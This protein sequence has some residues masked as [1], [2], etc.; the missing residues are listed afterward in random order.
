MPKITIKSLIEHS[1]APHHILVRDEL[2]QLGFSARSWRT[3]RDSG[4]IH[5]VHPGVAVT[6]GR[7]LDPVARIAAAVAAVGEGAMASHKSAA[8]LWGADV[9]GVEPI[10]VLR[11]DRRAVVHLQSVRIHRPFDTLD[12]HVQEVHGVPVSNPLRTLLDLGA[13]DRWAVDRALQTFVIKGLVTPQSVDNALMRHS[14]RGRH[15]MVALRTALHRLVLTERPP[16]S[17]L[18]EQMARLARRFGLPHMQFHARLAGYEV[19]FLVTGTRLYIECEG[20]TYHGLDKE[21]F[22]FDRIRAAQ[23][24]AN[25]YVGLRFTWAQIMRRPEFVARQITES[26][27]TW[28]GAHRSR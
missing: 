23:L 8:F 5:E 20:W 22:E 26:L 19:D 13:V 3:A 1:R 24:L 6:P 12:L 17:V 28:V 10:D 21:Q 4:L 11:P 2:R 9:V 16:D 18:E 27:K 25:G 15:G 14:E 7:V